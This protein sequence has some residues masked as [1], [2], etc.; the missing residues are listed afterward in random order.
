MDTGT[1][2]VGGGE[3]HR[4]TGGGGVGMCVESPRSREALGA[5]ANVKHTRFFGVKRSRDM[6]QV[7]KSE[8]VGTN[9]PRGPVMV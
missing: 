3:Q 7:G 9:R 5:R 6:C 1:R 8:S 4:T 2:R